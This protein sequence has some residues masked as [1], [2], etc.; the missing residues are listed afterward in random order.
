MTTLNRYTPLSNSSTPAAS[1]TSTN[2]SMHPL[3]FQLD[4]LETADPDREVIVK[5]HEN[6]HNYSSDKQN[7]R[8]ITKAR[9]EALQTFNVSHS[10]ISLYS[11]KEMKRTGIVDINSTIKISEHEVYQGNTVIDSRMG[12]V[13]KIVECPQCKQID[14]T[15]HF[16]LI[17]FGRKNMIYNPAYIKQVV[18]VL[19]CVCNCCGSLLLSKDTL[20]TLRILR[21][22]NNKRLAE[23][24]KESVGIQCMKNFAHKGIKKCSVNPIYMVDGLK[25]KGE[26]TIKQNQKSTESKT[27]RIEEVYQ[28]LKQIPPEDIKILGFENNSHPKNMIMRGILV[29]PNIARPYDYDS[30]VLYHN[31]LTLSFN[32]IVKKVNDLKSSRKTSGAKAKGKASLTARDKRKDLYTS[33]RQLTFETDNKKMGGGERPSLSKKLGSKTGILRQNLQGKR[34]DYC[35]RTV[36]GGA[37]EI[38]FGQIRLPENWKQVQTKQIK[39]NA[40]N[41][42]YLDRLLRFRRIT[43][44][45]PK[46]TNIRCSVDNNLKYQLQIGDLVERFMENGDRAVVNRQPTLHKQSMMG[47]KTVL[48]SKM[49]VGANLSTTGPM[50]LDF[51]GDELNLWPPRSLDAEAE[52]EFLL[53]VIHNVMSGEQN[54]PIMGLVMNSITGS[55][56]LSN[57]NT[58]I[59]ADLFNELLQMI[60]EFKNAIQN[61]DVDYIKDFKRRLKMY[62]VYKYSGNAILSALL[63]RD[64]YYDQK[65]VLV[66]DGILISGRLTKAHV[67]SSHRSF[68]QELHKNYG[69]YR[70]AQYITEAPWVINKWVMETGFTVGLRDV[71]NFSIGRNGKYNVNEKIINQELTKLYVYFDALDEQKGLD[72]MEEKIR[73]N[74]ISGLVNIAKGIG[75][76]L[77][78]EL[79][80]DT[81]GNIQNAVGVMTDRGAGTKGAIAN[82][83]QIMGSVSQQYY[84]GERLKPEITNNTRLLPYFDENDQDPVA[85]GF[86]KESFY[87]GLSAEGLFF[88]QAAGREGLMDTALKTQETGTIQRRMSNAF[89][90]IIIGTDGSVRNTTGTLF[91]PSYNG[92]YNIE[93][94]MSVEYEG[95]SNFTSF[96][97]LKTCM[98]SINVR[99]GWIKKS[100]LANILKKREQLNEKKKTKT[101]LKPSNSNINTSTNTSSN[102]STNTSNNTSNN[103]S[104]MDKNVPAVEP[105]QYKDYDPKMY[106]ITK[107]E[108]SRLIGARARQLANNSKPLVPVIYPKSKDGKFLINEI[109]AVIDPI[110]IAIR[111]YNEGILPLYVI[112]RLPNGEILKVR[113]TLD[114]ITAVPV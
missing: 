50:N 85:H 110:N 27:K 84:R 40:T 4:V 66:M 17:D 105:A 53:N 51:D 108:L 80:S 60:S 71:V 65:G 11:W 45:I 41:I 18:S 37:P 32:Q 35:G 111:E 21:L 77:A 44:I 3:N 92:G 61:D 67:G 107:F 26:I 36:A 48:D 52:V 29:P 7:L 16:G 46:V 19:T 42:Q 28:I 70:T 112:R 58:I 23:M 5:G 63:P 101:Q 86:I 31:Q 9:E 104:S 12:S 75:L 96:M 56:L 62:G 95:K 109:S 102:T 25:D 8:A 54:K 30:G 72:A 114:N 64:F 73:E 55:Y 100:K 81:E 34:V 1:S 83:G 99:H 82:I 39:V 98:E 69:P 22:K 2:T 14:C 91:S 74:E 94:M 24:A 78:K 68:I 57:P 47:Y 103:T 6:P 76:R 33:I 15:G 20:Q 13:S 90:S 97:D 89:N 87:K 79:L 49:T 10:A 106:K 93:H 59:N 113:P 43:H 38:K 88:L